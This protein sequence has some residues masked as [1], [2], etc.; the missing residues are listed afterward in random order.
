MKLIFVLQGLGVQI[1]INLTISLVKDS[2]SLFY[3]KSMVL[4]HFAENVQNDN[5]LRILNSDVKIAK[6]VFL[7]SER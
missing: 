1:I 2:F 7:T 6:D 4:T 5:S 3:L